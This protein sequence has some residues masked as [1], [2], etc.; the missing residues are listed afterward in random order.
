MI[1]SPDNGVLVFNPDGTFTFTPDEGYAGDVTFEYEIVDADEDTDPAIVTITVTQ[2]DIPEEPG[3]ELVLPEVIA[4][5]VAAVDY[6]KVTGLSHE[7][8]T[9]NFHVNNSSGDEVG[10]GHVVFYADDNSGM[11]HF[12]W[13]MDSGDTLESGDYSVTFAK[14][15]G[16]NAII[17]NPSFLGTSLFLDGNDVHNIH[18]PKNED[19]WSETYS[20]T[21]DENVTVSDSVI[22]GTEAD[23]TLV[24]SPE[25]NIIFAGGGDDEITGGEGADTFVWNQGDTG[26]DTVYDFS[27]DESDR[28][29]IADL[30]SD[31]NVTAETVHQ[32]VQAGSSGADLVLT[33]DPAGDVMS[34]GEYEITLVGAADLE[35][36]SLVDLLN[37]LQGTDVL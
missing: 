35:S 12:S 27:L 3:P 31:E 32:Y 16:G 28:L 30:L 14:E 10:N 2:P 4:Q 19:D 7:T 29:N 15:E 20:F 21:L 9:L 37:Q 6:S 11:R 36:Q 22:L 18:V 13:S 25:D 1:S 24:G 34:G 17:H 5:P 26:E 8:M 33:I 23:E